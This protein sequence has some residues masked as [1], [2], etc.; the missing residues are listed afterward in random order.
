MTS[1]D[2]VALNDEAG[3]KN[4]GELDLNVEAT[5]SAQIGVRRGHTIKASQSIIQ[6][7]M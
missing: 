1:P 3:G 2:P 7:H 4:L 5:W 6:A